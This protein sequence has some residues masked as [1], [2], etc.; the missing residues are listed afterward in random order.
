ME[1]WTDE[2]VDKWISIDSLRLLLTRGEDICSSQVD[3]NMSNVQM[4]INH[5]PQRA[6]G[7]HIP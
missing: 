4:P 2:Y 6:P 5:L 7:K 1:R 3:K